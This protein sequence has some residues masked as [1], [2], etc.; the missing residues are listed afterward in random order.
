MGDLAT[1]L[2]EELTCETVFK[3]GG[4]GIA[5]SD[6]HYLGNYGSTVT[7]CNSHDTKSEGRPYQ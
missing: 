1:K 6:S 2:Q 3:I 5:E 4:I 7:I